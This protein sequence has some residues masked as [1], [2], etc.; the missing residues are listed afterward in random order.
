MCIFDEYGKRRKCRRTC[1][2]TPSFDLFSILACF[3]E[4]FG[5]T[6]L[7]LSR[8]L[9]CS[10]SIEVF[11]ARKLVLYEFN[12]AVH[13]YAGSFWLPFLLA[14]QSINHCDNSLTLR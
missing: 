12:A 3:S 5:T 11:L 4:E 1:S 14:L 8:G 9:F 10:F 2:I 6:G 13:I 7:V